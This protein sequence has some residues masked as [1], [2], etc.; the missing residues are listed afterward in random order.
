VAGCAR[1][2][3][4]PVGPRRGRAGAGRDDRPRSTCC[5]CSTS[6][7]RFTAATSRAS[8][9]GKAGGN[10]WI[11]AAA[12]QSTGFGVVFYD[13]A[14]SAQGTGRANP[15]S[16]RP[17]AFRVSAT[18]RSTPSELYQQHRRPQGDGVVLG[19]WDACRGRCPIRSAVRTVCVDLDELLGMTDSLRGH[20]QARSAAGRGLR[21]ASG[22]GLDRSRKWTS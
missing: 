22:R 1:S 6:T 15:T 17:R 19:S 20:R 3:P 14:R 13:A 10:G 12:L 8:V 16:P 7:R 21:G 18:W 9:H 4:R 2:R 11:A 5:G